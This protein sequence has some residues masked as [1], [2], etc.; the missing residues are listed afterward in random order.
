MPRRV[1]ACL[2]EEASSQAQIIVATGEQRSSVARSSIFFM[3]CLKSG[4]FTYSLL[5]SKFW[6]LT[7]PSDIL[8]FSFPPSGSQFLQVTTDN[9]LFYSFGICQ[10]GWYILKYVFTQSF[11]TFLNYD[12]WPNE[13]LQRIGVNLQVLSLGSLN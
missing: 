6:Q 9:V 12:C 4:C 11:T 3:L 5:I 8:Y 2:Q 7:T 13:N 10:L 1:A